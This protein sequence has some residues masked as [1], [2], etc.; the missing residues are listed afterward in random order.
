[1]HAPGGITTN[2]FEYAVVAHVGSPATSVLRR[3]LVQTC[4]RRERHGI[5]PIASYNEPRRVRRFLMDKN[6]HT[7]TS[8]L[9]AVAACTVFLP[10]VSADCSSASGMPLCCESNPSKDCGCC[11]RGRS[12]ALARPGRE[13]GKDYYPRVALASA[14]SPTLTIINCHCRIEKPAPP[15][16]L[17][18]R[19]STEE[20]RGNLKHAPFGPILSGWTFA[21]F[22]SV[23]HGRRTAGLSSAPIYLTLSR[24]LI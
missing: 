18:E 7:L 10:E 5:F 1:M 17:P 2:H 15:A 19:S 4:V 16:R 9:A 12:G 14:S 23:F 24:L 22:G 11:E 13:V 21:T 8:L 20:R 3:T 6:R